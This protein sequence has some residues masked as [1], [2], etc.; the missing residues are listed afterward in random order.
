[1]Q[2]AKVKARRVR[3]DFEPIA[4]PPDEDPIVSAEN[5]RPSWMLSASEGA[6]RIG[7]WEVWNPHHL[8]AGEYSKLI[9][10][11]AAWRANATAEDP[12]KRL[13]GLLED[14]VPEMPVDL[15]DRLSPNQIL[16][17]EKKIWQNPAE[18]RTEAAERKADTANPPDGAGNS[19]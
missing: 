19:A 4:Q 5:P 13:R 3:I 11:D 8:T 2:D 16:S 1:M 7:S 9:A 6:N 14:C 17:I 12:M 18:T 15:F 10:A